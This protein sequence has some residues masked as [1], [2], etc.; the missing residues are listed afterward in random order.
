MLLLAPINGYYNLVLLLL[1]LL[2]ALKHLEQQPDRRAAR[3][4]IL[5]TALAWF[6]PGWT[7]VH[8]AVYDALHRGV[9]L[10]VLTPAIYGLA[11]YLGLL[12]WLARRSAAE[13]RR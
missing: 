11:I 3:W 5:A 7:D 1:P 4:L 8:P 13:A 10:L 12:L 6:P 9:G 2:A